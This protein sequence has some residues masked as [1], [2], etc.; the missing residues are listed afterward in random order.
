MKNGNIL[1]AI[2]ILL[3]AG[4]AAWAYFKKKKG[5]MLNPPIDNVDLEDDKDNA[6]AASNPDRS[7]FTKMGFSAYY[8]T[9]LSDKDIRTARNYVQ[10][11]L[12]KGVK[13]TAADPIFNDVVRIA[14]YSKLF[15]APIL[16]AHI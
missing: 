7:F 10:N 5:N 11:Y 3:L 16:E 6:A 2:I 4:L 9:R 14:N 15:N 12:N 8:L 1:V 13:I